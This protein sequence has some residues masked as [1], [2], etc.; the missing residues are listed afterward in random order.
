MGIIATNKAQIRWPQAQETDPRGSYN[1]FC[2]AR[3]GTVDL[4]TAINASP[5]AAWPDEAGKVGEGLA[6]DGSGADGWGYGG[7]GDGSGIDGL[8]PD[9]IGATWL[10]FT[11]APLADGTWLFGVIAYD[12]AG[13][14]AAAAGET[15]AQVTLA[16][17]PA[18]PASLAIDSWDDPSGTVTLTLG[19]SA[20]DEG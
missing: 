14:P 20:D 6:D 13:N 19:L 18:P 15:A 16:G 7:I 2:D 12:A 9:G 11:T 17:T 5:I 1:V 3:N 10:A 8:G 4:T